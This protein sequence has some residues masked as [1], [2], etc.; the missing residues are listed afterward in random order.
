[1]ILKR[2]IK[3]LNRRTYDDKVRYSE[4]LMNTYRMENIWIKPDFVAKLLLKQR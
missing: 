3:Y 1:M 4:S 2:K